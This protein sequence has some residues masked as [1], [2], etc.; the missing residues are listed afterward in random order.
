MTYKTV[1][2]KTMLYKIMISKTMIHKI[3]S[4]KSISLGLILTILLSAVTIPTNGQ[5][6]ST[7][8]PPKLVVNIVV[9]A[10]RAGDIDRYREGFGDGGFVRLADG[11][12]NFSLAKYNF[13]QTITPTSLATIFTGA[14]PSSH[15]VIGDYWWEYVL[16]RKVSLIDEKGVRNLDYNLQ[17]EGYSASKLTSPTLSEA[18]LNVNPK[19]QSVSIAIEPSSAIMMN[20]AE[21]GSPYWVDELTCEWGS[22]TAFMEELPAWVKIY[23]KATRLGEIINQKWISHLPKSFYINTHF[24]KLQPKSSSPAR[25]LESAPLEVG[26]TREAQQKIKYEQIAYTP[27]GNKL[28]LEYAQKVVEVMDLGGDENP[29]ILN[30]Y[31]DPA[32]NIAQRYGASAIETEDMFRHLDSD[33]ADF[34]K[35]LTSRTP[36]GEIIFVLTSDHGIS[37]TY[38][39][40]DE[41]K[42]VFNPS[43]FMV[44]ISSLLKARY[45][46]DDDNWVLGYNSRN[47]YLNRELIFRHGLSVAEVQNEAASFALQFRGVAHALTASA[48]RGGY[49]GGG[50]GEKMQNSFYPSRSGDVVL[51]FMP[52]WI[53]DQEGIRA[54]SGSTYSYDNHVPLII[55]GEGYFT[56]KGVAREVTMECITPTLARILQIE[57]PIATE[58][59]PIDEVVGGLFDR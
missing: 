49:F 2:S 40:Y 10:M 57:S 41:P 43:Q 46:N 38:G 48:L 16:G 11:G 28:I 25:K 19:S 23:N 31:F 22:S 32:R 20:G 35:Y 52:G 36:S 4:P 15:G 18:L 50:Y 12:I 51:N 6:T 26:R 21:G 54:N 3:L 13:Q 55:Y 5:S 27:A 37:P 24:T 17:E 42:G 33:L 8:T 30:I 56:R 29:D 53:E 59:R 14:L 1:I 47:L 44:L 45:H 39:E 58:G 34:I 9:G 7:Y